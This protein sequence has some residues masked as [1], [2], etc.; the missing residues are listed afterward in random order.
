VQRSTANLKVAYY[1][2]SDFSTSFQGS[3]QHLEQQ[4]EE[5]YVN[6]LK[7]NCLNEK[8][9]RRWTIVLF[10]MHLLTPSCCPVMYS[11]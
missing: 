6:H 11:S 4:V 5:D 9:Y 1:V 3:L 2:K 10:I 7:A 8:S